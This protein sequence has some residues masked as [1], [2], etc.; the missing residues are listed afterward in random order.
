MDMLINNFDDFN[1]SRFISTSP[2]SD[3]SFD[4]MQEIKELERIPR[5]KRFVK[6]KDDITSYFKKVGERV[7]VEF[8]PE[9]ISE[10]LI[11]QTAPIIMKLKNQILLLYYMILI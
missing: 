1:I 8:Y 5:N 9:V 2:P 6:E 7:G 11:E 4:T 3:N 10:D